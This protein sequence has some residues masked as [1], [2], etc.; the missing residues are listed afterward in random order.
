METPRTD[1]SR[2]NSDSTV[3]LSSSSDER[4]YSKNPI[5]LDYVL[6]FIEDNGDLTEMNNNPVNVIK[7]EMIEEDGKNVTIELEIPRT[8]NI[9]SEESICDDLFI[10]Y[11]PERQLHPKYD[12]G[13]YRDEFK[14]TVDDICWDESLTE[15]DMNEKISGFD[16]ITPCFGF[17]LL[18]Y[19]PV[20]MMYNEFIG[21][22]QSITFKI[23][24][25]TE[26]ARRICSKRRSQVIKSSVKILPDFSSGDKD[27]E[28]STLINYETDF[29]SLFRFLPVFRKNEDDLQFERKI[30]CVHYLYTDSFLRSKILHHVL[31]SSTFNDFH[32]TFEKYSIRPANYSQFFLRSHENAVYIYNHLNYHNLYRDDLLHKNY[33]VYINYIQ[34]FQEAELSEYAE[35]YPFDLYHAREFAKLKKT[36]K[37]KNATKMFDRLL[38][39]HVN[40]INS[41]LYKNFDGFVEFEMLNVFKNHL[42]DKKRKL[43]EIPGEYK[44]EDSF[45]NECEAPTKKKIKK[46]IKEE[47]KE[48]IKKETCDVYHVSNI[49]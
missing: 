1:I 36:K 31:Q 28:S 10:K 15:L 47:I 49:F 9:Y 3:L 41:F 26:R 7:N 20:T 38:I 42:L 12:E 6:D 16:T 43:E 45:S 40:K 2:A 48:E 8:K 44:L 23:N 46:E 11:L 17:L 29:S 13:L 18:Y 5:E 25:I 30:K 37:L 4:S 39:E 35:I 34:K 22:N 14:Y 32:K 27:T 24:A 19:L 21:F 33:D